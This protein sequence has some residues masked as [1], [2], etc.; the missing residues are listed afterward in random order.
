MVFYVYYKLRRG[1]KIQLFNYGN[2][3]RDFTFIDDI[4]EGVIRVM[5]GPPEKL[6]GE[7]GLPIPPYSIYNIGNSNPESLLDFV[8]RTG[9]GRGTAKVL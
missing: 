9:P 6:T 4:V 5:G 3:K 7:D 1:E 2:C 8:G